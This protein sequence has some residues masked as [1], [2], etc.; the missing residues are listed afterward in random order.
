[1]GTRAKGGVGNR[2]LCGCFEKLRPTSSLALSFSCR[3]RRP[4]S[5]PLVGQPSVMRAAVSWCHQTGCATSRCHLSSWKSWPV[6]SRPPS[7]RR[8][9]G[10]GRT[11]PQLGSGSTS[12]PG[13]ARLGPTGTASHGVPPCT[14][15]AV[16]MPSCCRPV[17]VVPVVGQVPVDQYA[18]HQQGH[19]AQEAGRPV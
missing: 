3:A 17:H 6:T 1:M 7:R 10:P 2:G 12:G 9:P 5:S 4:R 19:C 18:Y 16:A 8:G 11:T 14:S 15:A 13:P